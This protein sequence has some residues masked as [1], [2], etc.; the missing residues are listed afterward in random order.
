M[1]RYHSFHSSKI[2]ILKK[3]INSSYRSKSFAAVQHILREKT[4]D[5]LS[6]APDFVDQEGKL[7]SYLLEKY[8]KKSIPKVSYQ[9]P[10]TV[11]LRSKI[12]Q[13]IEVVS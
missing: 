2:I 5:F 13:I 11:R 10:V 8:K 9:E 7:D 1:K 6:G 3:L 4:Y 12:N